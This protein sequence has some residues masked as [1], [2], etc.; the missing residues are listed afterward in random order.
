M[1]FDYVADEAGLIEQ[2][3]RINPRDVDG[4]RRFA[5]YSRRVFQKGY[6]ELARHHS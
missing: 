6:E 3:S 2:I 1:V 4:Y 5:D